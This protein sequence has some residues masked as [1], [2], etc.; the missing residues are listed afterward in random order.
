MFHRNA[1][2]LKYLLFILVEYPDTGQSQDLAVEAAVGG[3]LVGVQ[4]GVMSYCP[5][6]ATIMCMIT[7]TVTFHTIHSPLYFINGECFSAGG[8]G[9]DLQR[10]GVFATH[11]HPFYTIHFPCDA[12]SSYRCV[13]N[14]TMYT[15]EI[16]VQPGSYIIF[17]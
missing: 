10:I 14:D 5:S 17:H 7:C 9:E 15:Q 1:S 11:N 16:K 13:F 12:I 2:T 6:Q 4:D 3:S 8:S